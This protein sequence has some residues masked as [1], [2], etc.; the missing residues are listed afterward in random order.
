MAVMQ[1]KR[2]SHLV[3]HQT[4]RNSPIPTSQNMASWIAVLTAADSCINDFQE[5]AEPNR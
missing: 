4:E 5:S 3:H 2:I 1:A